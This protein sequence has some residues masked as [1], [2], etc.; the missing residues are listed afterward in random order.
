MF[1]SGYLL[2][3]YVEKLCRFSKVSDGM[4]VEA[5]LMQVGLWE[6]VDKAYETDSM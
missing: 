6:G 5:R 2:P 4:F 1:P 3:Y